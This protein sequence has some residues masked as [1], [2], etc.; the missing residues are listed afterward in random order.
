MPPE[1]ILRTS[2]WSSELAKLAS[3]ALPDQRIS[4]IN[5]ISAICEAT[6]ADITEVSCAVGMDPRIGSSYLESDLGFGG[7]CL[8]KDTLGLAYLA[9][10]F[11]L[12][13]AA[14]YLKTVVESS[15]WQVDRFVE[16]VM[17]S[18]HGTLRGQKLAIFGY[19]FK[20]NTS[21]SRES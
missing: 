13:E 9:D 19:A 8:K 20:E 11:R 14:A 18:L 1:S 4:S 7:S 16:K 21:D 2:L 6:G 10:F 15:T 17:K 5:I 3:D 12:P